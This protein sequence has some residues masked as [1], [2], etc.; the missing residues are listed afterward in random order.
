MKSP[1]VL[2]AGLLVV[3]ALIAGPAAAVGALAD[4]AIY[5]RTE[6][7][8][9]PVYRHQGR[10]YVVGKPGNEYQIT[11]QNQQGTDILSVIS[12][13]GVNAVS[14]ETANWS[15]TGYVSQPNQ[16]YAVAG[17]RKSLDRIAA[18]YFT[19]HT[20]SY[21]AR[22]GRPD[23]VGVIGV[24][25]FRRKAEPPVAL[26]PPAQPQLYRER[27]RARADAP[28]ATAN[29]AA[30][31]SSATVDQAGAA[32]RLA[33]SS[34]EAQ[35]PQAKAESKLGT[36]HGRIESSRV[37]HTRF[38]REQPTPNEVISIYYDTYRNLVAQGVIR[39]R[40][41]V[42]LP[43]PFPGQFAPDPR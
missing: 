20:N 8:T 14:G 2:L 35:R 15:Q 7:R 19:E 5:D 37:T 33:E 29:E 26:A 18:F 24:A 9:L 31:A 25:V 21:A 4:I 34:A 30:P 16:S 6:A 27:D 11:V 28:A 43:A 36:G 42:A 1:P 39:E 10:Y 23:N 40:P 38:E 22:T 32:G 17:W 3:G 12:V 13:D 41:S